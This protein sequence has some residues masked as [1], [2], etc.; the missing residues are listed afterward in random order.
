MG[1]TENCSPWTRE[2]GDPHPSLAESPGSRSSPSR[3]D[4]GHLVRPPGKGGGPAS[5]SHD[6][7]NMPVQG[8]NRSPF[9]P[10]D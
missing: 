7:S 5:V 8:G 3:A 1:I 2:R 4:A 10:R 6:N 9:D